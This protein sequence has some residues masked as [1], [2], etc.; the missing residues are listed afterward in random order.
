MMQEGI[1]AA[2]GPHQMRGQRGLVGAHRP[3]V[4]VMHLG[5]ALQPAEIIPHLRKLDAARHAVE[6]EVDA[7]AGQAPAAP[8]HHGGDRRG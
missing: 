4:E 5:D 7:V 3:D 6:R 2:A 8:E 1:V